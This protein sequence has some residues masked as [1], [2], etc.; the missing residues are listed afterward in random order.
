ME[1][2]T[3]NIQSQY[4]G[5]LKTNPL[6][7]NSFYGLYQINLPAIKEHVFKGKLAK[8]P[9]LGK[10]VE[11]FVSC[12]LQQFNGIKIIEENIQIQKENITIGEID[13]ILKQG[14]TVIHLEIIFKYYLY[15]TSVGS[16]EL[17]HWI[18][19]NKNDSLHQKIEKLSTKQLPLLY[20]E[21][22]KKYFNFDVNTIQQKVL[23]KAQLFVPYF[24]QN[25]SFEQLNSDCVQG[26][27]INKY[28]LSQFSNCKFH[29]PSKLNWLL[30]PHKN[31]DWQSFN[32]FKKETELLLLSKKSP[33]CWIK[34]PNGEISK[35]FIVWW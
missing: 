31:V 1:F 33:L 28:E 16:S 23:F 3:K 5:F 14:D 9:R 15:D 13:S 18:G 32:N 11:S 7:K 30:E 2:N 8:N 24:K 21:D 29:I 10:R 34:Q 4:E 26:F 22:T 17:E 6:W 27:Y 35:F 25:I 12:F 19:P 20:R